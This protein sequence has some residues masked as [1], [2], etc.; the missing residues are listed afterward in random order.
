M[1]RLQTLGC[2]V[3]FGLIFGLSA[4]PAQ[5]DQITTVF[6]TGTFQDGSALSGNYVVDVT[7]GSAVSADLFFGSVEFNV[8]PRIAIGAEGFGGI[9][10]SASPSSDL[11]LVLPTA[12][13]T[14]PACAVAATIPGPLCSVSAPCGGGHSSVD[15][16]ADIIPLL[17]GS[18]VTMPSLSP[19]SLT[20]ASQLVGTTSA[21]QSVTL[22]NYSTVTLSIISVGFTGADPGDFAQT[23]TRTW[24][25]EWRS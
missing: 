17:N 10:V 18:A 21:A 13:S 25:S 4:Q 14:L 20:F 5:A 2:F 22:N 16:N 23:N 6:V 9:I 24:S 7:T 1:Y 11:F 3:V 8:A 19:P 15:V 12:C